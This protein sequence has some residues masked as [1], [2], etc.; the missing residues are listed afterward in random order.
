MFSWTQGSS[1][2]GRLGKY[3][4]DHFKHVEYQSIMI[5]KNLRVG[6]QLHDF[7]HIDVV[8]NDVNAIT[9][10]VRKRQRAP[11]LVAIIVS[12]LRIRHE[13]IKCTIAHRQTSSD[14]RGIGVICNKEKFNAGFRFH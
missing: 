7:I 4:N 2:S 10:A 9:L 12:P 8:R 11:R 6:V 13:N 3:G 5:K 14:E 1:G